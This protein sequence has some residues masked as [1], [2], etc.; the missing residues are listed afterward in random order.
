MFGFNKTYKKI[1]ALRK[2]QRRSEVWNLANDIALTRLWNERMIFVDTRDRSVAPQLLI[3]GEWEMH[4]T[5]LFLERLPTSGTVIDCGANHG[6]YGLVALAHCSV[7]LHFIEANP[8]MVSLIRD[9]V[10]IKSLSD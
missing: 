4:I 10:S 8:R 1:R 2:E 6:Y 9:S 3:C 7:D 5:K